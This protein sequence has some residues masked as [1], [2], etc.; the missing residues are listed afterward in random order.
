MGAREAGHSQRRVSKVPRGCFQNGKLR[1]EDSSVE[2]AED[3]RHD[4]G[5]K[6]RQQDLR[7]TR[8][9]GTSQEKGGGLYILCDPHIRAPSHAQNKIRGR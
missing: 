5:R 6:D 4:I 8:H 3:S 9:N 7:D 1:R 2:E